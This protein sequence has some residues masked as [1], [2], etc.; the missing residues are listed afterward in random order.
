MILFL[1]GS[2][3]VDPSICLQVSKFL[4]W[5]HEDGCFGGGGCCCFIF[6]RFDGCFLDLS[7]PDEVRDSAG[8]G[9]RSAMKSRARKWKS[10]SNGGSCGEEGGPRLPFMERR[11]RE[12]DGAQLLLRQLRERKEVSLMENG[13]G[14]QDMCV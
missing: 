6:L 2:W 11:E 12:S 14:I 4:N 8:K 9:V 10:I 5:S 7:G 3:T 13:R 1:E